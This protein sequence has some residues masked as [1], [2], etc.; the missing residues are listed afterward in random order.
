MVSNQFKRK[1]II[2]K[3]QKQKQN[4]LNILHKLFDENDKI[5]E[6]YK[7]FDTVSVRITEELAKL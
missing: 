6:W 7:E 2:L 1:N 4:V 5:K 3:I